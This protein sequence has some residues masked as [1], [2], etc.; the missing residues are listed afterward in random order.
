MRIVLTTMH[1]ILVM[2]LVVTACGGDTQHGGA[3]PDSP[4]I[5]GPVQS[6]TL[7][8]TNNGAP[9]A[10]V[11]VYF[12][13][14]DDA[15]I[16]TV[17][18]A[19]DG[20]A[21][22]VVPDGGSVTILD[23]YSNPADPG[24]HGLITFMSVKPGDHLMLTNSDFNPISFTLTAPVVATATGYDVFTTCG[25][26]ALSPGG[27][28]G[29]VA[30]G[31]VELGRCH[32]T[33]D[34]AVVAHGSAAGTSTP[35]SGLF[36]GDTAVA[37]QTAV[38]LTADMYKPLTD[39]T[40]TYP[41]APAGQLDVEHAPLLGHGPLG[42]FQA[43]ASGGTATIHEPM[44]S[45]ASSAVTTRLS[46]VFGD[47]EVIDWGPSLQPYTL[48]LSSMLLPEFLGPPSF[49]FTTG[50]VVWSEAAQG[51][52]PDATIAVL[53]ISRQD[54]GWVWVVIAPY[55]AGEARVPRLPTDINDWTPKLDDTAFV[56][57]VQTMKLTG[58]YDA[59]RTRNI[60][61][62]GNDLTLIAGP[63]GRIVGM[64]SVS[65]ISV[66]GNP[67]L[68]SGSHRAV[69]RAMIGLPVVRR[70]AETISSSAHTEAG[71]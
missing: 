14:A 63:A 19:A 41:N 28:G 61:F 36:H 6:V 31:V 67:A 13:D 45:A 39:A 46:A 34:I 24:T 40:F 42:P 43:S 4:V 10:G 17:D 70:M 27:A 5:D 44:I 60:D 3:L 66:N 69:R 59:L 8:V 37:D 54:L 56:D 52:T 32:G 12:L 21:G 49:N 51:A 15:V 7:T 35:L 64:H 30:S 16:A 25:T 71:G 65:S 11:H 53:E 29:T 9:V 33:A 18:T 22:A 68:Q 55:R 47:H 58:G 38:D 1:R 2:F 20:T 23:A 62:G 50:R 26:G 57:H 48:D